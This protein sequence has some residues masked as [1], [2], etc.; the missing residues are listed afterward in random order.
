MLLPCSVAMWYWWMPALVSCVMKFPYSSE[1]FAN[2]REF[3]NLKFCLCKSN[4]KIVSSCAGLLSLAFSQASQLVYRYGVL[5][6]ICCYSFY[7]VNCL[8]FLL[9]LYHLLSFSPSLLLIHTVWWL[10]SCNRMNAE[11]LAR[12]AEQVRTGGPGSVR[13]KRKAVH[14]N[15]TVDEKKLKASLKRLGVNDI[16]G[17]EEVNLFKEDGTVIHFVN[18]KG[19]LSAS[20]INIDITSHIV[21]IIN[22]PHSTSFYCRIS[23]WNLCY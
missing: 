15:V 4:V 10:T 22:T 19:M 8:C 17:I 1:I 18:P 5:C 2:F 14:K 20:H 16:P 13:R 6:Y 23:Q 11:K 3:R 9:L 12:L 7:I 21:Q